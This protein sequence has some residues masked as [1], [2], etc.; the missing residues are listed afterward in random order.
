MVDFLFAVDFMSGCL[1]E[2]VRLACVAFAVGDMAGFVCGF[3]GFVCFLVL[4]LCVVGS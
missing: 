2:L 1:R 3:S 4:R